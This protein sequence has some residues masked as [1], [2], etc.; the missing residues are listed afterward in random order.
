[1]VGEKKWQIV[2][3]VIC[4][5]SGVV[6]TPAGTRNQWIGRN[7][8]R[9]G[10]STN[11]SRKLLTFLP[12]TSARQKVNF[13]TGQRSNYYIL[14]IIVPFGTLFGRVAKNNSRYG[15]AVGLLK[16]LCPEGRSSHDIPP[17]ITTNKNKRGEIP[18]EKKTD[19]L[20]TDSCDGPV[21]PA[22]FALF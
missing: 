12:D 3:F 22:P 5:M 11:Q 7:K 15:N 1:M 2:V 4:V 8:Y 6:L 18:G 14:H 16:L 21:P 9:L 19:S 10:I 17:K 13:S 20:S